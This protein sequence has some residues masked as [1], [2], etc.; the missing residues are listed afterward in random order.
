MNPNPDY[1]A[2]DAL[3]NF[4]VYDNY[5]RVI[6]KIGG[7]E[8]FYP[9]EQK[10]I[11]VPNVEQ[12]GIVISKVVLEF[13]KP[14][15]QNAKGILKP[16]L[17]LSG[18]TTTEVDGGNVRVTGSIQNQGAL[19]ASGVKIT[20][21]IADQ[22][23]LELFVSQTIVPLIPGFEKKNFVVIFPT[24]SELARQT[25]PKATKVFFSSQ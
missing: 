5:D 14:A 9:L 23:G 22:F 20:A 4:L 12:P 19:S 11:Y 3:Y 7:G 13:S 6:E 21:I 16:A 24:D 18:E 25:D 17:V 15:W 8:T 1:F 10:Y 2:T